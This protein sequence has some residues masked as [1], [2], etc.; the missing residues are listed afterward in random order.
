[1]Q[2]H[3][4]VFVVGLF[5]MLVIPLLLALWVAYCWRRHGRTHGRRRLASILEPPHSWGQAGLP[6]ALPTS[7]SDEY[8]ASDSEMQL[9]VSPAR[10]PPRAA[11]KGAAAAVRRV[12]KC[13]RTSKSSR[14]G[15]IEEGQR[16]PTCPQRKDSDDNTETGQGEP[17]TQHRRQGAKHGAK[18]TTVCFRKGGWSS[19]LQKPFVM[20]IR[21]DGVRDLPVSKRA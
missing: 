13:Q 6:E 12:D 18:F 8:E 17:A 10:R 11:R 1:M 19:R 14:R 20:G 3:T 9:P 21:L 2:H 15:D 16:G 5:G 4:V 7:E